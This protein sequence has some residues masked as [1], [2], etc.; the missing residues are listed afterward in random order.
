MH[1]PQVTS[2]HSITW[3]RSA[4]STPSMCVT[5]WV[6]RRA[7]CEDGCL[8]INRHFVLIFMF[9]SFLGTG[10]SSQL[11]QDEEGH[12]RQGPVG[13]EVLM[14]ASYLERASIFTLCV[15]VCVCVIITAFN[16][17]TLF[18]WTDFK[19]YIIDCCLVPCFYW[20]YINK[21]KNNLNQIVLGLFCYKA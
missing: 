11:P 14:E 4:L 8:V 5:R 10:G 18:C 16:R 12:L 9:S 7:P 13:L 6:V 1:L 15:C 21:I 19:M 2:L 17:F 3:R 20:L